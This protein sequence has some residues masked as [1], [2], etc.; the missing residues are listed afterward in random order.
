MV[1]PKSSS[2]LDATRY[3]NTISFSIR[4]RRLAWI[5]AYCLFFRTLPGPVFNQLRITVLRL[6]G[7]K[8]GPG[9]RI[10]CTAK[11]WAPWN[12]TIGSYVCLGGNVD[13]YCVAPITLGDK[14]T[15]SQRA[16]LCSASHDIG[17]LSRPLVTGSIS[18]ESHAWICAEAMVSMN[19]HVATGA[20]VGARAMVCKDVPEWAVVAGNPAKIISTRKIES[21]A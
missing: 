3:K 5:A 14:V 20:V 21:E 6:F 18:I 1:G 11:I 17:K 19:V 7:A 9:C 13:F 12:M 4:V 15:I 8:I 16:F 10:A 2:A